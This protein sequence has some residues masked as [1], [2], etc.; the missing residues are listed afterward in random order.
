MANALGYVSEI[1][2]RQLE[3][4]ED[5]YYRQGDYI[6]QS[7]IE[8][9]YEEQL[10][11]QKGVKFVMQNVKG[12]TKG[13]WKNGELDTIA[14]AGK[15]LYT[16]IDLEVQQYADSLMVNKVG[17]VVAIEPKTGQILTMVSAPSYD[18]N[19]L[20]SRNFAK[21]YAALSRNPYKPLFNRP[22]MASYRPGST[23]KTIQALIGMQEG[24]ITSGTGFSHAGSPIKCHGHP[25]TGNVATSLQYSCNPY[26]YHVFRR[27]ILKNDTG[28][29]YKT[30]ANGLNHWYEYARKFGLADKL[31]TDLPSEY[32]GNLPNEKYY[33][34]IY[35]ANQ[36]RF[37]NIYSLSIGE[38]ELLI[39][40]IKVANMAAIIA[41]KGYYYTPHIVKQIGEDG[42]PLPEYTIRHETGIDP[43]HFAPVNEGMLGA[44]KAGTTNPLARIQGIEIAGKTGTSQNRVG[45][46]HSIFMAYAPA[47]DPK[48]AIA[49]FVENGG[50]G[51]TAAA[52]VANLVIEKYLNRTVQSKALESFVLNKNYMAGVVLPK[53]KEPTTSKEAL[54]SKIPVRVR[55]STKS[56]ID[57]YKDLLKVK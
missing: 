9:F 35:G 5:N 1:S 10:R 24:V 39:T 57:S 7:G 31:G 50:F 22:V 49:V 43:V 38:G 37:S 42:K 28:N 41:N 27:I 47:H 21:N 16:G 11:G 13:S 8:A 33:N 17:S 36:W 26:Y 6:G 25:G 40:P 29:S 18:P 2:K 12:I 4:R 32:K 19:L 46:D 3:K 15:N 51:G 30:S 53:P 54:M 48:I 45:A 56:E 52:T 20:T 34:K 23:F 14:V 44:V 55:A